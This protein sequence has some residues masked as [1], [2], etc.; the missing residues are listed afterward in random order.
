M[1]ETYTSE[2]ESRPRLSPTWIAVV[3]VAVLV[4]A[5]LIFGLMAGPRQSLPSAARCQIL[6]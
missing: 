2:P 6:N 5:V 4:T 1:E 3:V